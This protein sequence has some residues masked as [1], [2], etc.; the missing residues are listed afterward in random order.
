[1]MT[2]T[3]PR[4]LF[5][6]LILVV[7]P[8]ATLPGCAQFV[9]LSYVLGGPPSIEPDFD[10]QTGLSLDGKDTT[11]AVV[12]YVP[13]ELEFESPKIDV[14][15]ASALAYRL[16]EHRINVIGPDY[17]RAWIDEHPDWE[18]PEEIGEALNATYVIDI[19]LTD[20]SLYEENTHSLYR[21]RAEV[22]VKVIE[23][24]EDGT[25]EE[26]YATELNSVFPQLVPRSTQENSLLE[27]KREYL[28]RLSEE[29]GW[30][31]YERYNGDKIPWAT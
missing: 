29:L 14:E 15:V 23:M 16:A 20:F 24:L 26:V 17:V 8:L 3:F 18:R 19:E 5:T 10:A 13:T 25:G 1:M 7:C 28:S 31:F 2:K 6:L 4:R 30:L 22:Y 27:F 11:V 9:L 21:G 12:C